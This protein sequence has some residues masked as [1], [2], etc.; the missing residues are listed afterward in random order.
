MISV[1]RVNR[2]SPQTLFSARVSSAINIMANDSDKATVAAT[3]L[4]MV[5][6]DKDLGDDGTC[7]SLLGS[8]PAGDFRGGCQPSPGISDYQGCVGPRAT[9]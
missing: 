6:F 7:L 9:D 2:I 8:E 4:L 3:R 1:E 5:G